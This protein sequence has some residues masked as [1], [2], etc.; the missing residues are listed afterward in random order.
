M[1]YV[2][3]MRLQSV[4]LAVM[5]VACP[6]MSQ[7]D[8]DSLRG[9]LEESI[10]SSLD[11]GTRDVE[12]SEFAEALWQLAIAPLD[13]N[14]ATAEELQQI[15]AISPLL[16]ARII[17]F[18][19]DKRFGSMEDLL[20]I[21]GIDRTLYSQMN[22]FLWVAST[23]GEL[24]RTEPIS[25]RYTERTV[26]RLK[27]QRG[28]VD[29]SYWG[30]PFKLYNRLNVRW[31]AGSELLLETG[32]LTEK[33]PGEKAL[34]EF[35]SGFLGVSNKEKTVRCIVGDY[36]LE[37]GQ[38][39]ALWRSGGSTKGTE[40]IAGITKNPRGLQPY[41]SSDENGFLRGGAIELRWSY[42]DV[43]AFISRK[44]INAR[45]DDN[46][47]ITSLVGTG[48]TRNALE[49]QTKSAS[50]ERMLGASAR[51]RL[52]EG[53]KI[54]ISAYSTRFDNPLAL[55][56]IDG[57]QGQSASMK[58][59]DFSYAS[60]TVGTF[61]EIALDRDN[62]TAAIAGVIL[63]PV[64]DLDV[65][66]VAHSYDEGFAN[67]HGFA[68]GE[69]G[70]RIKNEQGV[71]ASARFS[72]VQRLV[73]SAYFDQYADIGANSV[74]LLPNQGNEFLGTV[75]F[76]SNDRSS[77]QFEYKHKNQADAE[78]LEDEFLR[79]S[80]V[81]GKRTQANYRITLEWSPSTSIQWKTRF[82]SV[83]VQYSVTGAVANGILFYQDIRW[84]IIKGM[85]VDGRVASFDTDSYDSR[86]YEYEGELHGTFANPAL[87]GKGIRMYVLARYQA[88]I[89]EFSAKYSSTLKPGTRSLGTGP[90]EIQGDTDDQIGIQI[91]VTI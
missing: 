27:D 70:G 71:Y 51:V 91:D 38:G 22:P 74:S 49:E 68:F 55:S 32:G 69:S 72:V 73:F 42:F 90:D 3:S 54:G 20:S 43:T 67:L 11:I 63:Q 31:P 77:V 19:K 34:T 65:A 44:R 7:S 78:T 8:S 1:G 84:R 2:M 30:N 83:R 46:G 56:G 64:S 35:T 41:N 52:S 24:D 33:D 81:M 89:V 12:D 16:A 17:A 25:V 53:L 9:E 88:G 37:T 50:G 48:L 59:L 87:F 21:E 5:F 57:F 29:G 86:I 10:E 4:S 13:V 40:V 79:S 15:P 28:F 58:S 23:N 26:K 62:A 85:S 60:V 82:E 47:S 45:L 75:R 36:V 76:L 18:R 6:L 61:G 39:L 14:A 80:K 66:L